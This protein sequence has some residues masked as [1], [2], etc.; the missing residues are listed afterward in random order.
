MKAALT[1]MLVGLVPAVA[2]AGGLQTDYAEALK[3]AKAQNKPVFAY[4]TDAPKDLAQDPRFKDVKDLTDRFVLLAA[5]KATPEGEKL[6]KLFKI[7]S[8]SAV[9]VVDK[10][11]EWQF[12]RYLRDLDAGEVKKVLTATADANGVP[13]AEVLATQTVSAEEKQSDAKPAESKPVEES[14]SYFY[15]P[16]CQRRR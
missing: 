2:F 6:F 10:S 12:C 8:N 1:A 14:S 13:T 9:V 7:A 11:Q 16:S 15:C 3:E 5:N 4:F